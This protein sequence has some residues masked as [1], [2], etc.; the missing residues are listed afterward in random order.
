MIKIVSGSRQSRAFSDLVIRFGKNFT[1]SKQLNL[2]LHFFSRANFF[3]HYHGF[4]TRTQSLADRRQ[5]TWDELRIK[6]HT[7]QLL[8]FLTIFPGS[9]H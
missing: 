9:M 1:L 5:V 8:R 3:M 7:S 2:V 4:Y 6:D